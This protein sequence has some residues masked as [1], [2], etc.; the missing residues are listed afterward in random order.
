MFTTVVQFR[1]PSPI[2]I[3]EAS[4]RFQSSA[5]KY[6]KLSGL[7]RKHYI[8]SEDGRVAG[9]VYH[10]TSR[11]AAEEVYSGEWRERVEKLYGAKPEILWFESPV[12]VDNVAGG[13]ITVDKAAAKT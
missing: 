10:W 13:A 4:R 9:G 1:L 3:D 12:S 8:V 7:V 2:T 5:P 6:V 11:V